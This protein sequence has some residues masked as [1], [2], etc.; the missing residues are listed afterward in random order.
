MLTSAAPVLPPFSK[1][2]TLTARHWAIAAG[3]L[4]SGLCAF[5]GLYP[6]FD[7]G[8]LRVIIAASSVAFGMLVM[9]LVLKLS[10]RPWSAMLAVGLA[11]LAGVGTTVIPS[12]TLWGGTRAEEL[13]TYLMFGVIF[14]APVGFAYGLPLGLLAAIV[15]P[16]V[17][18]TSLDATDRGKL[19]AGLWMMA[20]IAIAIAGIETQTDVPITVTA[21][22]G[23]AGVICVTFTLLVALRLRSR[24]S[25][26]SRIRA[27]LEPSLRVRH[28]QPNDPLQLPRFGDGGLVIEWSPTRST[29]TTSPLPHEGVYRSAALGIPLAI[30]AER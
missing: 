16:S 12:L 3:G 9:W 6:Q 11:T 25:W 27:G 2:S 20:V 1:P 24:S 28:L 5:A 22:V 17:Y 13:A 30:I 4:G 23:I 14:G 19:R 15:H 10:S 26:T 8:S 21:I 7:H 29:T 18:G